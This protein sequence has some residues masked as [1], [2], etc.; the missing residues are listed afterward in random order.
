LSSFSHGVTNVDVSI[1][2]LVGVTLE[3]DAG[4]EIDVA[5]GNARVIGIAEDPM[6][7]TGELGARGD[8]GL[9]PVTAPST[10]A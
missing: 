4:V 3:D 2:S 5:R 10:L 7:G 1:K 9:T 8:V 6:L